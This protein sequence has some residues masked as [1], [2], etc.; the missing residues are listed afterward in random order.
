MPWLINAAQV[1][2][3]RKSQKNV[4]ILDASW[5]L[6]DA[7]RDAKAEFVERHLIGARFFDLNDFFDK[8]SRLPNMILRDEK[9]IAEKLSRLGISNDFKIIFYDNSDLHSSCRAL[10]MMKVFGHNPNQLY[11]LDGGLRA[12]ELYDGKFEQG[13]PRPPTAK[14]YQV[15]FE[16]SHIRTMMQMKANLRNPT[17]QVIDMRHAI[18]YAGG[19]ESRANMR[20]GHVPGSFSFPYMTMF[21]LD[22]RFKAVEKIQ[23]QLAGIGVMLNHPIVTMCGSGM[24]ASILN[25]MLDLMN[26]NKHALYDG[27]WSEWGSETLYPGEENL[28]ERPVKTSVEE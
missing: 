28:A 11:I 27:S 17:E 4:I 20:A 8:S 24:T 9:E 21:E 6:P 26:N 12:W 7:N 25:F 23:K 3:F 10:W 1:D 14:T 13:E 22:G 5:H 18:R 2:K 19:A 16:P 15:K